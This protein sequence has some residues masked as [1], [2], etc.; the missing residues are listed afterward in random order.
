M[1]LLTENE[2]NKI[3]DLSESIKNSEDYTNLIIKVE[4]QVNDFLNRKKDIFNLAVMT[5]LDLMKKI[6]KRNSH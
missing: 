1:L 5:V 4:E 3:K 6:R 2:L